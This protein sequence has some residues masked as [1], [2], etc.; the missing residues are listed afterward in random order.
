MNFNSLNPY[1]DLVKWL[2][3]LAL[4][5]KQGNRDTES[6]FFSYDNYNKLPQTLLKNKRKLFSHC[7]GGRSSKSVL[8]CEN[9]DVSTAT[10]P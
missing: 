3:F 10:F 1:N 8:L 4:F 2:L 5:S 7:P 9:Q 6:I